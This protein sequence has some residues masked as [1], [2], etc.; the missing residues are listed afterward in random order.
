ME[1][2]VPQIRLGAEPPPEVVQ[3]DVRRR[4]SR[5]ARGK[6]PAAV[7]FQPVEHPAGGLGQ[8]DGSR[9]G[10]RIAQEQV[11]LAVVRPAERQ[12]F[13]LTA[14]GQKEKAH[15]RHLFRMPPL[16]GR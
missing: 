4:T 9:P 13:T 8:P 11:P 3:P 6:H 16:V 15:D 5:P 14:S 10:L 1:T 12:N 7:P 2:N